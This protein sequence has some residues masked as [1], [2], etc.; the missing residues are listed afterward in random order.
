MDIIVSVV[1]LVL[2][3]SGVIV[4]KRNRSPYTGTPMDAQSITNY[5]RGE[6]IFFIGSVCYLIDL[7]FIRG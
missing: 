4:Q 1:A 3:V 7:L 5:R 2:M 6:A